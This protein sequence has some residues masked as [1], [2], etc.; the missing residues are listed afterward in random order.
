MLLPYVNETS[1]MI[2]NKRSQELKAVF[3]VLIG[4]FF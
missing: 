2:S 1:D 4:L 3:S